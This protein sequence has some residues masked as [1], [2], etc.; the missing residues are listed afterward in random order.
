VV[1]ADDRVALAALAS[2]QIPPAERAFV[3]TGSRL[4]VEP[5]TGP[6]AVA[7]LELAGERARLQVDASSPALVVLADAYDIGW[8]AWVDGTPAPVIRTNVGQRGVLVPAGQHLVEQRYEPD[9][10]RLGLVVSALSGLI[11]AMLGGGLLMRRSR[12]A[13]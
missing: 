9:S 4:A 5:E 12:S 10:W 13:A 2:S 3:P 7:V 6:E 1:E 8:H 11:C